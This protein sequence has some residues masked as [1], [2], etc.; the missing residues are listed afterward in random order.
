M[1]NKKLPSCIILCKKV[2]EK[3]INFFVLIEDYFL[4]INE[5]ITLS[6]NN[7]V[8]LD[9]H[10]TKDSKYFNLIS[11]A[12][13]CMCIKST[14][15]MWIITEVKCNFLCLETSKIVSKNGSHCF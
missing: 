10:D 15:N 11:L 8:S 4:D 12:V 13:T 1:K 3:Y 14:E 9:I 7:I 2:P 6:K 5:R